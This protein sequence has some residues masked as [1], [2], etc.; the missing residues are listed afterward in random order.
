[1]VPW[2]ERSLRIADV[3]IL[4]RSNRAELLDAFF[5][6][7]K[8]YESPGAP[9]EIIQQYVVASGFRPFLPAEREYPGYNFRPEVD[10]DGKA[11]AS[12]RYL[13]S[14]R[15]SGGTIEVPDAPSEPVVGT[16][17]GRGA[18]S[19]LEATLRI[20]LC[21]AL[22]RNGGLMLHSA[23]AAAA[24]DEEARVFTGQ[25]GAG[26]STLFGLLHGSGLFRH[27]LGDEMIVLRPDPGSPTAWR[28]HAT[29]FGGERGPCARA[30]APLRAIYFLEKAPHH[31]AVPLQGPRV[32]PGILRNTLAYVGDRANAARALASATRLVKDV[33][34]YRLEFQKDEHVVS[35]LGLT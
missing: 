7:L 1:M 11:G 29:P 8:G 5:A 2:V 22:L 4:L 25:S 26:K 23:G 14:R 16:F 15:D 6:P 3:E 33:A 34:T 27:M 17:E 21:M 12:A 18:R 31:R 9:P 35:V 28:A 24:S 10:A 32:V 20:S 19:V 13:F 30:S